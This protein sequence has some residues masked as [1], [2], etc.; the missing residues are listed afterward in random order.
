M[1][2]EVRAVQVAGN[3]PR[4]VRKL[5]CAS[6]ALTAGMAA[7]LT[8]AGCRKAETNPSAEAPQAV[9][10][11]KANSDEV[12]VANPERFRLV[13]AVAKD[14]VSKL[15]VTGS[16]SPDVSRE[17]PVL[18]LA[19]GRVVA[20]LVGLG[21]VVKKGQL[22]M[23][24]QSNDVAT[25][26]ATYLQ[27][28]SN[29]HLAKVTL[30]RD[31]LL[32]G[33]GAIAQSQVEAAQN[34][35]DDAIAAL[36]AS[37]QQLKILGVDKDHPS[38]TVNVYSPTNGVVVS[39]NVTN[40]AAAGVTFA[41]SNGSLTIADLSHVW[42]IVDVYEQDLATV[43]VG[44]HVEI[45]LN[46]Y[47]GQVF[48]GTISDI[49]ATL[50]PQL[51]TAKV[52]IQVPNRNNEVRLGMFAT[53]TILGSKG[54]SEAAIPADAVLHLHD[55]TY[56]FAPTGQTGSFRRVVVTTGDTLNGNLVA[57]KSGLMAGQQVVGNALDLQNTADNQ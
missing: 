2:V 44:Q 46:A 27:S 26:F 20:L 28:V 10:V 49:G 1:A 29:E 15:Q 33:K 42:V 30:D 5:I 50:D 19:N 40:A 17:M 21:D 55:Q 25:A 47:P 14:V 38:D 43:R 35:E 52:R 31:N 37:E 36:R 12:Q 34:G 41:G 13:Y 3:G 8:F 6:C 16:V 24:V 56:V 32:Y 23:K 7:L 11:V 45:R 18:S 9:T 53:A 51:R 22:V 57:V 4:E 54:S 48:D 39:Q